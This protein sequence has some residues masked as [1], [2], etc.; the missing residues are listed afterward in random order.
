MNKIVDPTTM[1]YAGFREAYDFFN[2]RLFGN[3]L[4]P[5][6]ITMQRKSRTYGYYAH[7]RFGT[8]DGEHV[9][10]ELALNPAK[11]AGHSDR[12]ILSVLVHEMTHVEQAA[13][14]KLPRKGYHDRQWAE[15]MKAVGL[16][17]STTGEPGGKQVGQSV[18]H[19]IEADGKFDK[20]CTELMNAGFVVPY[21]DLWTDDDDKKRATKAASKTRY[22]CPDCDL[23]M[24]GKPDAH[25]ICGDCD[26][27]MAADGTKAVEPEPTVDPVESEPLDVPP[28]PTP[29]E[30]SA[31]AAR[32]AEIARAR[33]EVEEEIAD[34]KAFMVPPVKG[35][36]AAQVAK[37][38]VALAQ[39]AYDIASKIPAPDGED[40]DPGP[41]WLKTTTQW[42]RDVETELV[43]LGVGH[44]GY[45][46]GMPEGSRYASFANE[47]VSEEDHNGHAYRY[48]AD[49]VTDY[50]LSAGLKLKAY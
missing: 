28:P 49:V 4:P 38:M 25:V 40:F 33:L 12:E 23:N 32:D 30:V 11:F 44:L 41:V 29:E 22:T 3:R 15:M 13:F 43:R 42:A 39:E 1:N 48:V 27:A 35:T 14:G 2:E 10:N 7:E 6:L 20:A 31:F 45:T 50:A 18:S 34:F 21:V 46:K 36:S 9:T 17:P 26:V 5:C 8:R 16:I 24:W 47:Y 37:K 19:Y